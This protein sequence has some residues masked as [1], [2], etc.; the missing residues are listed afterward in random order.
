MACVHASRI[1]LLLSHLLLREA[2]IPLDHVYS[3]MSL[4]CR[5][6]Y[7]PSSPPPFP[8]LA[9][10]RGVDGRGEADLHRACHA[11]H[12]HLVAALALRYAGSVLCPAQR[13]ASAHPHADALTHSNI[14]RLWR[15]CRS[16]RKRR[17]FQNA[18]RSRSILRL[19]KSVRSVV[20]IAEYGPSRDI[21]SPRA[22]TDIGLT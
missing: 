22:C 2:Y 19:F 9:P 13:A 15:L 5:L 12:A 18:T 17:P 4:V 3:L 11:S 16:T 21:G 10:A 8:H 14:R 20:T 1:V 6:L 7:Y